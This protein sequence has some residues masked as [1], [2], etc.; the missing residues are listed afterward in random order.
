MKKTLLLPFLF[1]LLFSCEEKNY[2]ERPET[3]QSDLLVNSRWV[4]SRYDVVDQGTPYHPNDTLT[5]ESLTR[6]RTNDLGTRAYQLEPGLGNS[7]RFWLNLIDCTT[8]SGSFS[9]WVNDHAL[10]DGELN[11]I[12]FSE[13]NST[14]QVVVWMHRVN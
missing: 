7:D 5:F 2:F 6:Y 8:L 3:E 1:I 11:G 14:A 4:I 10:I 12:T 9:A 13:R